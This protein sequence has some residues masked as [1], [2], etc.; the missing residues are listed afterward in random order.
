M[1]PR[2]EGVPITT[3]SAVAV[4]EAA[5]DRV[6]VSLDDGSTRV[7]DHILLATGYEV[8]ISRYEFLAP[9]LL[10][11]SRGWAAIRG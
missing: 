7:A 6:R 1:I 2:L 9:Q 8:D 3:G 5:G 10:T 11:G 4:A